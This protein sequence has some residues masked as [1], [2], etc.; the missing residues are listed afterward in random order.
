MIHLP[1]HKDRLGRTVEPT[2]VGLVASYG[3]GPQIPV[4]QAWLAD[5]APNDR[6]ELV[7]SGGRRRELTVI[8]RQGGEVRASS[9]RS[10]F[11][12][13]SLPIPWWRGVRLP[14]KGEAGD[15]PAG[16]AVALLGPGDPFLIRLPGDLR[17]SS[18]P[19]L[20]LP[21][22][23]L[24]ARVKAGERVVLDDAKLVA[25]VEEA[26][27]EGLRCRVKHATSERVK[28]RSGKGVAFPDSDL[29]HGHLGAHDALALRVAL[30]HADGVG[31]SFVN[32]PE[33]V[34]LVGQRIRE[35]GRQGFGMILKLETRSATRHLPA[36]LFEALQYDAVG[37]MI[38]RGDLA[39]ELSFERLAEM[40]EEILWFGE[41]CHLPVI[42]ATQVLDSAAR[43]G[44]PT[45]AEITDA[46]MSM[47]AECV[48]L[49][50]GPQIAVATRMLADIISKM[51]AHQYKKRALY[52]K[53][54]MAA[55]A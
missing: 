37:L 38:A 22:P 6:L 21:E 31:V 34:S 20:S 11:L 29:E 4:P 2:I 26:S 45:R 13:S 51:E 23:H 25:V 41:A 14:A 43:C 47:R 33:D 5:L 52:R 40:Q 39:V 17:E 46:A 24:L 48:M 9:D 44:L 28:L 10:L 54:A 3:G 27:P 8:D 30:E 35:S 18:M 50:K 32:T 7:D 19:V 49:N 1:R 53:L 55:G 16:P 12:T 42:W 36:I 15:L